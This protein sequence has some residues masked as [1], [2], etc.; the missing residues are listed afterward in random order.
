MASEDQEYR[1]FVKDL[2]SIVLRLGEG[3]YSYQVTKL[4]QTHQDLCHELDPNQIAPVN[5]GE[6]IKK[7][8]EDEINC[9][10]SG[11]EIS[12]VQVGINRTVSHFESL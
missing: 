8:S 10:K 1:A 7:A 3:P 9:V 11:M 12:W 4:E 2:E 6:R 5:Y